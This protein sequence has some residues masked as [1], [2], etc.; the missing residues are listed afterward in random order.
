MIRYGEVTETEAMPLQGEFITRISQCHAGH[1]GEALARA[2][3]RSRSEEDVAQSLY[4]GFRRKEWARQHS[5]RSK[6]RIKYHT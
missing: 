6:V 4:W 2:R 1:V 3:S 5:A